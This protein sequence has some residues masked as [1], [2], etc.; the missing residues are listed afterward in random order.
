MGISS[1]SK[2]LFIVSNRWM[3]EES[4]GG[5]GIWK[6]NLGRRETPQWVDTTRIPI[7]KELEFG[8][9][10]WVEERPKLEEEIGLSEI[11]RWSGEAF[12]S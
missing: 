4:K 10:I 12:L 1:P 9:K 2:P 8:S 6:Q 11:S 3:L 7:I 5:F